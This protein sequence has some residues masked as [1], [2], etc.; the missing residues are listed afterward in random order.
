MVLTY[1]NFLVMCISRT[2]ICRSLSSASLSFQR[3]ISADVALP[4]GPTT[5]TFVDP[6]VTCEED[7]AREVSSLAVT[8]VRARKKESGNRRYAADIL[9]EPR[10]IAISSA[11]G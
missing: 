5:S 3:C 2:C 9:A 1:V 10:A 11:N 4:R 6:F 8:K 7:V